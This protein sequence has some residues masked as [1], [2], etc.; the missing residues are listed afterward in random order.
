[1]RTLLALLLVALVGCSRDE[2]PQPDPPSPAAPE[3]A[4]ETP[5]AEVRVGELD[6]YADPGEG[7]WPT[8]PLDD[9]S[10][11][12]VSVELACAGRAHQGDPDSHAL[13]ARK[14]LAHHRTTA[15]KVGAYSVEVNRS[16]ARSA[17]LGERITAAAERCP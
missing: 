2:Q 13:A 7:P 15:A 9:A 5:P 4:A 6:A 14:V 3:A 12:Q 16:A 8:A 11:V 10:W 1:M 17:A